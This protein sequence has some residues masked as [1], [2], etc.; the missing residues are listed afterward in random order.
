MAAGATPLVVVGVLSSAVTAFFYVRIIVLMFFAEPAAEAPTVIRA[1]AFTGSA[2]AVG[3]AATLVLG[4]FPAPLLDHLYPPD[5]AGM[6]VQAV[7][8][9]SGFA[10]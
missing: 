2:I 9:A 3:V 10:R 8:Q 4:V 7:V 5:G 6:E 1:G